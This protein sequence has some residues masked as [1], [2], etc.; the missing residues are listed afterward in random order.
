MVLRVD[1]VAAALDAVYGGAT[2]A[3]GDRAD[4]AGAAADPGGRRGARGRAEHLTLLSARFEGFDE[5]IVEHLAHRRD[6]DR[7]VRALE[8]RSAG[9]GARRR[10]RAAL[11][12]RSERRLGRV[13]DRSPT[14]SVAASSTLTTRGRRNSAAGGCPTCCSRATTRESKAGEGSRSAE[15]PDRLSDRRSAARL[16]RDDRLARHDRRRDRDRARDQGS[17]SSTRTGS[18]RARWSRRCTAPGPTRGARRGS[19]TGCSPAA[20]VTTSGR[21]SA[22]TS[23]SSTRR[24]SRRSAAGRAAPSS[25]A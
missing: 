25:S 11:A 12:G 20:S 7:P 8:R 9:D 4:P 18:R 3:P 17:G 14:S 19:P 21:R 5:R 1:V 2:V 6:L 23:S 15:E 16:A 24:R 13:R 22:A 10:D